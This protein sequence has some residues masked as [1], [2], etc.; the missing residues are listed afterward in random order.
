MNSEFSL[1]VVI[2]ISFTDS[3][4]EFSGDFTLP[5]LIEEFEL[6][7]VKIKTGS[8]SVRVISGYGP[9][10]NWEEEKRLLFS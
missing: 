7:V 3:D 9:Q 10:E 5:K 8:D 6:L 1:F 2:C 4:I